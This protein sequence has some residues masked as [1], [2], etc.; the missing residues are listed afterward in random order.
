MFA[1][2]VRDLFIKNPCKSLC[3]LCSV[4]LSSKIGLLF[5]SF[6]LTLLVFEF[7]NYQILIYIEITANRK[8]SLSGAV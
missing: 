2:L 5:F 8:K 3:H 7:Q 1:F 6:P 4:G